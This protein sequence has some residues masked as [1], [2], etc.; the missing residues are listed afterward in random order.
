[1]TRALSIALALSLMTSQGWAQA[2]SGRLEIDVDQ[3]QVA[4][5]AQG[6]AL[7]E[8]ELDAI[9]AR[10]QERIA[11][12]PLRQSGKLHVVLRGEPLQE[13]T[14]RLQAVDA[15]DSRAVAEA[16]DRFVELRAQANKDRPLTEPVEVV[17][18]RQFAYGAADMPGS[19]VAIG[20]NGRIDGP[21]A[22]LIAVGSTLQLGPDAEITER[23]VSVGSDITTLQG[24]RITGQ[25]VNVSLPS[26][27]SL[28]FDSWSQAA[29]APTVWSRLGGS[30]IGV[31]LSLGLGL[32]FMRLSPQLSA[33][34]LARLH[35]EPLKSFGIGLAHYFAIVPAAIVLVIS[36]V[37]ILLLPLYFVLLG[38]LFWLAYVSGAGYLGALLVHSWAPWQRLLLGLVL[39]AAL[40]F[41]PVLGGIATFAVVTCGLGA[42]MLT[43]YRRGPAQPD[44]PA[45]T[46][47]ATVP[48][49]EAS[50]ET[51]AQHP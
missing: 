3:G 1:M 18:G 31:L 17:I 25:Q 50:A 51:A 23:F 47:T 28:R 26:L 33:R 10:M 34:S 4:V 27:D 6:G 11:R 16:I 30:V 38:L 42:I 29:P 7:S 8:R 20:A 44:R 48:T 40:S 9:R 46:D 32:L 12:S 35:D 5:S 45:P 2:E 13:L 19:V 24:A 41:I 15:S 36:V 43:L 39:L 37:G 22:D 14:T 21:L 49:L